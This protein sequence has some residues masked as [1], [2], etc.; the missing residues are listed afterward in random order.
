MTISIYCRSANIPHNAVRG[1]VKTHLYEPGSDVSNVTANHC[2]SAVYVN[3][4]WRLVDVHWASNPTSSGSGNKHAD[5]Y[6]LTDPEH[7]IY[8]HFPENPTW[9]LLARPL[10]GKEFHDMAFLKQAFFEHSMKVKSQPKCI[11]ESKK[12]KVKIEIGTPKGSWNFSY[13]LH[14]LS[15]SKR[16]PNIDFNRYVF[17]DHSSEHKVARVVIKFPDTGRYKL[18]IFCQ[19]SAI[20]TDI[21][22]EICT[23]IINC[24]KKREDCKKIPK[25][26]MKMYGPNSL[27]SYLGMIPVSSSGKIKSYDGE[28]EVRFRLD[29]KG[30]DLQFVHK[31]V[32]KD[33]DERYNQYLLHTVENGE[34]IFNARLPDKGYYGLDIFAKRSSDEGSFPCVCSYLIA[35]KEKHPDAEAYTKISNGRLGPRELFS[36]LGLETSNGQSA[37]MKASESGTLE[38]SFK[39]S[40]KLTLLPKLYRKKEE[41]SEYIMIQ[42]SDG[43]VTFN[44]LFPKSGIYQF[45]LFAKKASAS[46][47]CSEIYAGLIEADWIK[48]PCFPFPEISGRWSQRY[49]LK[50]PLSRYLPAN[51]VTKFSAHIP[52][53]VSVVVFAGDGQTT[54]K[55]GSDDYWEGNV[56]IAGQGSD[57]CI[58]AEFYD[59]SQGSL[60]ELLN[61]KVLDVNKMQEV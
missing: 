30:K 36:T 53:A 23:Y 35:C 1:F 33:G 39:T 28:I 50:E 21:Y 61:Y 54:L 58:T 34:V 49:Q 18:D 10:S 51:E 4:S 37:I 8:S 40:Q 57:T 55:K 13:N 31:L 14:V 46:G 38:L 44:I 19:D 48:N 41:M 2:W 24:D 29:G 32:D 5:F 16:Y 11:I 7:L 47:S 22:Q 42:T 52:D 17:A 15:A 9:Q 56:N 27:T 25:M 6:F 60:M 20:Q 26:G 3:A 59:S 45:M 12:G 43:D